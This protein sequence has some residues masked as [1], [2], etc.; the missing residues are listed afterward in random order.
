MWFIGHCE[1]ALWSRGT[2]SFTGHAKCGAFA[3]AQELFEG[4][5]ARDEVS[6]IT[7]ILQDMIMGSIYAWPCEPTLTGN[8]V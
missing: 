7:C 4:K 2:H 8:M 1:L 3:E 5:L 6:W